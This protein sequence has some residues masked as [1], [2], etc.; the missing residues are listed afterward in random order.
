MLRACFKSRLVNQ[1][2]SFKIIKRY[3]N[4]KVLEQD[5]SILGKSDD[6]TNIDHYVN[7]LDTYYNKEH[8]ITRKTLFNFILKVLKDPKSIYT[9]TPSN[10]VILLTHCG[11]PNIH[12][13]QSERQNIAN[14]LFFDLLPN[15]INYNIEH[16][17]EYMR[18]S[19]QNE[20][21][22]KVDRLLQDINQRNL[23]ANDETHNQII[24]HLCLNSSMNEANTYLKS[25]SFRS[26]AYTNSFI[27]GYFLNRNEQSALNAYKHIIGENSDN[28]IEAYHELINGYLLI[29]QYEK[30]IELFVLNSALDMSS[31]FQLYNHC[32]RIQA[33]E[34]LS[35]DAIDKF[36]GLL[37][38][39]LVEHKK[40]NDAKF[41]VYFSNLI[42][43][44]FEHQLP[45][46]AFN[47]IKDLFKNDYKQLSIEEESNYFRNKINVINVFFS[48]LVKT[49]NSVDQI[50]KYQKEFDDDNP[51]MTYLK[52]IT[53]ILLTKNDDG[54]DVELNVKLIDKLFSHL[55]LNGIEIRE[56]FFYPHMLEIMKKIAI[57]KNLHDYNIYQSNEWS[58]LSNLFKQMNEKYDLLD[59]ETDFEEVIRFL[60][61]KFSIYSLLYYDS[62]YLA[63]NK[64]LLYSQ[65]NSD[66]LFK[67]LFEFQ[68]V[69]FSIRLPK[70]LSVCLI[71]AISELNCL[72]TEN[73][74]NEDECSFVVREKLNIYFEFI[75]KIFTKFSAKN[76]DTLFELLVEI[77]NFL[78]YLRRRNLLD[79]YFLNINKDENNLLKFLLSFNNLALNKHKYDENSDEARILSSFNDFV[80]GNYINTMQKYNKNFSDLFQTKFRITKDIFKNIQTN[81]PSLDDQL[82]PFL[83]ANQFLETK[84]YLAER[85]KSSSDYEIQISEMSRK[86]KNIF[87]SIRSY[88]HYL[89]SNTKKYNENVAKRIEELCSHLP[90]NEYNT[91]TYSNLLVYYS[92]FPTSSTKADFYFE[93]LLE[94][95]K[96]S[97]GKFV[98]ANKIID[99]CRYKLD[100]N[101]NISTVLQIL[102]QFNFG[103]NAK[104]YEKKYE[105]I[106][107]LFIDY[108]GRLSSDE[109]FRISKILDKNEYTD[110]MDKIVFLV[111]NK[112]LVE[113]DILKAIEILS[114]FD[115]KK[116]NN[117]VEVDILRNIWLQKS[118][119][120]KIFFI[121]STIQR[122]NNVDDNKRKKFDKYSFWS[123]IIISN[124][125][126]QN[127]KMVDTVIS[128]KGFE[129]VFGIEAFR[130]Y[131]DKYSSYELLNIEFLRKNCN[132]L[133]TNLKYYVGN[134]KY[135]KE[136]KSI[137]E[138]YLK[139]IKFYENKL[140][141]EKKFK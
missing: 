8:G 28:K 3:S 4:G 94:S 34:K 138:E 41:R 47:L 82:K 80:I 107:S 141:A 112:A 29:Q 5:D 22:V 102:S 64:C 53:Y 19:L 27:R 68:K 24:R 115:N 93:K 6:T 14:L 70:I 139:L 9:I 12:F 10:S 61:I 67:L 105:E 45:D 31:I 37:K 111:V 59:N 2:N 20:V 1:N 26:N 79:N 72:V 13:Y 133:L 50:L 136:N 85:E 74:P 76:I 11:L 16:Y 135:F 43:N 81:T 128:N 109:L 75:S 62:R 49:T 116:D 60:T 108:F 125:Q 118:D 65:M 101:V 122:Q 129:N 21:N 7:M 84:N 88:I 17:N 36:L 30:A 134:S 89:C 119:N 44:L 69:P 100:S 123:F 132:L 104:E 95:I 103:I 32:E 90:L 23:H 114:E 51:K 126:L 98:F 99:Y 18:I 121:K 113:N 55:K 78:I 42:S 77:Q 97:D 56:H 140:L 48:Y 15:R 58:K 63:S 127:F 124:I 131:L 106:E 110:K 38:D 25:I 52:K 57:K 120:D 33:N 46:K 39:Q 86:G 66:I 73:N 92:K 71:N 96:N 54:D 35:N 91:V 137:K 83:S 130:M 40:Q 87:P 117:S